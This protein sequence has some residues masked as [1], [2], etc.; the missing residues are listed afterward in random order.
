MKRFH[1][2]ACAL[3]LLCLS[4]LD[5]HA[6][7]P[8]QP[9][10]GYVQ[11]LYTKHLGRAPDDAGFNFWVG[12]FHGG[13]MTLED[14]AYYFRT[15]PEAAQYGASQ[16]IAQ[17]YRDLLDAEP[18]AGGLAWWTN[19]YVTGARTMANIR[20]T[21][22]SYS[23]GAVG[24]AYQEILHRPA[25]S[26]GL[27]FYM[28]YL[29]G[30]HTLTDVRYA[31]FYSPENFAAPPASLAGACHE[32]RAHDGAGSDVAA[33]LEA[34]IARTPTGGTLALP[35]G[36]FTLGRQVRFDRPMR[37]VTHFRTGTSRKCSLDE[38]HG[39]AELVAAAS[40]VST[41]GLVVVSAGVTFDHL[42]VNG[43]KAARYGSYA[44][45][46]CPSSNIYGYNATF[47]GNDITITNSVFK[48][49]LCGTG[50]LAAWGDNYRVE[51]N[52][53]AYNGAH[54]LPG[55]WADGLTAIQPTHSVFS[56]NEIID[57]TDVDLIFG[58]CPGCIIRSNEITHSNDF[59]TSSF[60][61]LMLH[62]WPG[63]PHD[64]SS[65]DY[66]GADVSG[67]F[68]D[69][70][71]NVAGSGHRCGFGVYLGAG[72]WYPTQS[73]GGFVHDNVVNGAQQGIAID[74]FSGLTLENNFATESG[75]AYVTSCGTRTLSAYNIT[76]GTPTPAT[77]PN[78]MVPMSAFTANVDCI[79]NWWTPPY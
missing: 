14:I 42:V 4:C 6:Y 44:A 12:Q 62:A 25:D 38:N 75:G 64:G 1:A 19:E 60:A 72:A 66:T 18:D 26:G 55:L 53:V 24:A 56:G 34:C 69:C 47:G 74:H 5:V 11:R 73:Y 77:G 52:T 36:K 57:N 23:S 9:G 59:T 8:N 71:G 46:Q 68:V 29:A 40:F 3:A 21:L 7:N 43:N 41:M 10:G 17:Y 76:P 2:W 51:R 16:E 54:H 35:R 33:V 39:C 27:G 70:V 28:S 13:A 50:L 20:A 15:S 37:I 67:N 58:Q 61:A 78:N 49:A 65:G 45:S 30:G 22:A 32:L 31:L 79:P 48:N 63:W